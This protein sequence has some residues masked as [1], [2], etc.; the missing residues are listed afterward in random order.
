[1]TSDPCRPESPWLLRPSSSAR[2][3]VTEEDPEATGR[4]SNGGGVSPLLAR[5]LAARGFRDHAAVERFLHPSLAHTHDPDR[6]RDMEEAV[7]R[8]RLAL[9]RR[10]GICIYGDYDVD[11]ITATAI[12]V[13]ALKFVGAQVRPYI[14][15]RLNE[16]YGLQVEALRSLAADGTRLIV[17]V[18][19][20]VT[21]LEEVEAAVRLGMEVIIV[22]H[23]EPGP[24]LPAALAVIN[25][26]RP[27]C[28]YPFKDLCAAGLAFKVAHALLRRLRPNVP[29]AKEHLKSLLDFV[30]LGTVADVVALV[31]ENRCFVTYGLERMRAGARPGLKSLFDVSQVDARAVDARELAFKIA[32]RLNA[33]GRTD[34]A[35]YALDLLL[36]REG[37]PARELA[38][39]LDRFNSDRRDLEDEMTQEAL[40]LID[41][42]EEQ[43]VI[44]VEHERWHHGVV[45]IVA[46]RLLDQYY[47][48]TIVLGVEGE[49][50]KGSARSVEGFD[51]VAAFQ[52]CRD[53]LEQFGGHAMAAGLRLRSS[54]IA[55]FRRAIGAYARAT[56]DPRRLVRPLRID[57]R[58]DPEDI[59]TK[60][61]EALERMGPFGAGNP[62]PLLEIEG[63]SLLEEPIEVK[64][65]KTPHLKLRLGDGA[66][67][68]IWA[69][70]FSLG[71]RI[72]EL[73]RRHRRLR[74]AAT[75]FIN[76]WG[77]KPRVELELRDFIVE[78]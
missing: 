35:V 66:G 63:Y 2:W 7:E 16:G 9:E 28:P 29:E 60:N 67:G 78:A 52:A 14:P 41:E 53:H 23:H 62:K 75:P 30:A 19:N 39:L 43:P 46:S 77:G 6:L 45:G 20:G 65:R 12:L 50:A 4:L 25:P 5:I 27:D 47:R 1:M 69:I 13:S 40:D 3:E 32:P 15:H 8:L 33:A 58:A 17:A 42:A 49:W 36:C 64:G 54:A 21:A 24:T 59:T 61:V 34:H 37:A 44:I 18:D 55:A 72:G 71:S 48:P 26:K 38:R 76:T 56:L 31:D 11:G 22:D 70:G 73:R 10:E 51:L 74:L 68:S 57:T